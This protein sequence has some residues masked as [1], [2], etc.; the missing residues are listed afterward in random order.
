MSIGK[1]ELAVVKRVDDDSLGYVNVEGRSLSFTAET[2]VDYHGQAFADLG[3]TEGATVGVIR[4]DQ[5]RIIDIFPSP[6]AQD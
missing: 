4:D 3:I 6:A 2:I 1:I 5:Y